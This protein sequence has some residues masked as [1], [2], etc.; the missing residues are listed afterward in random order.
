MVVIG[1]LAIDQ[2]LF[3]PMFTSLYFYVKGLAEDKDLGT[4]TDKLKKELVGIMKSNWSVWVPANFVNYL[5]IPL[6]LRVLF[7]S[8]VA[9]FWNAYLISKVSRTVRQ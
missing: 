4:T 3:A 8:V 1:K 9:F 5:L 2:I 6:E 7:G